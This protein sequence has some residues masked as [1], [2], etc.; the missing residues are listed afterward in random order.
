M[1]ETL[2]WVTENRKYVLFEIN[3]FWR[4]WNH[5]IFSLLKKYVQDAHASH[6]KNEW[7]ISPAQSA[8]YAAIMDSHYWRFLA[9]K[10]ARK[11]N[12]NHQ[13]LNPICGSCIWEYSANV[14]L[15]WIHITFIYFLIIISMWISK[16]IFSI[17]NGANEV[18]WCGIV[19][20]QYIIIIFLM[21]VMCR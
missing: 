6:D 17:F 21:L 7:R 14:R 15:T 3:Y 8:I 12:F 5:S 2:D 19:I 4:W 10:N 18:V 11:V 13:S 16:I 9:L 20:C 1:Y